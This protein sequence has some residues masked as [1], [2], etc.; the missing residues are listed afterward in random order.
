MLNVMR[1]LTYFLTVFTVFLLVWIVSTF[2]IAIVLFIGSLG[3]I[4]FYTRDSDTLFALYWFICAL[5][6]FTASIH[7]TSKII[8]EVIYDNAKFDF[9]FHRSSK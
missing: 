8:K 4:Y 3:M 2:I 6:G 9:H 7:V 5:G 1:L